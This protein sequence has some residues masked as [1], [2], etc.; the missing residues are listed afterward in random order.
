MPRLP[1]GVQAPCGRGAKDLSTLRWHH[2]QDRIGFPCAFCEGQQGLGGR[3]LPDQER[4]SLLSAWTEIPQDHGR[5]S[6]V[7]RKE[8]GTGLGYGQRQSRSPALA[9]KSSHLKFSSPCDR[10]RGGCSPSVPPGTPTRASRTVKRPEQHPLR[11]PHTCLR[12][13]DAI[14]QPATS[15]SDRRSRAAAP[16]GHHSALTFATRH[17]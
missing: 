6:A 16:P 10:R 14:T 2:L 8:C 5:C 9:K 12:L 1:T 13:R 7:C 4:L 3:G 15:R 17:A 11:P